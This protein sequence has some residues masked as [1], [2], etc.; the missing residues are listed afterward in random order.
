MHGDQHQLRFAMAMPA[1]PLAGGDVVQPEQAPRLEGQV[2][3]GL[4]E[5]DAAALVGGAA[6]VQPAVTKF[7]F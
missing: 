3:A 1:A 6:D 5:V 2:L 7:F 4:Q